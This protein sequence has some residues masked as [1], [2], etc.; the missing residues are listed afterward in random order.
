T[1]STPARSW[2]RGDRRSATGRRPR[3]GA[4]PGI[5]LGGSRTSGL[6]SM[7]EEERSTRKQ[8]EAPG[9]LFSGLEGVYQPRH[10][11]GRDIG[12]MR[13]GAPGPHLN[14][15]PWAEPIEAAVRAAPDGF[16]GVRTI[17]EFAAMP[18]PVRP[19]S[20]KIR[21]MIT[22]LSSVWTY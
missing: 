1:P 12:G 7:K 16:I 9:R 22:P 19:V 2:P 18:L 6:D 11:A 20:P 4:R 10:E 15:K 5:R 21:T 13:L 14:V 8:K 17:V 3:A